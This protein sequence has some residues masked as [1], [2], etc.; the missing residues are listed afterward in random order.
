MSQSR[1][2]NQ[3]SSD[4][5]S[6]P[7]TKSGN[8]TIHRTR[9]TPA[10]TLCVSQRGNKTGAT[11]QNPASGEKDTE[12]ANSAVTYNFSLSTTT[13]FNL[14]NSEKGNDIASA[15]QKDLSTKLQ[16]ITLAH[17]ELTKDGKFTSNAGGLEEHADCHP[18]TDCCP[19]TLFSANGKAGE[20]YD[21][22]PQCFSLCSL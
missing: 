20:C 7:L 17:L 1:A 16:S 15:I 21:R 11:A 8:P 10:K 19:Q 2:R 18:S 14:R 3:K 22:P 5:S 12:H 6:E 13:A 4:A 9:H